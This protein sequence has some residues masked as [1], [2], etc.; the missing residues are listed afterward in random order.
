MKKQLPWKWLYVIG[1]CL[2]GLTFGAWQQN[3]FAGLWMSLL[4]AMIFRL[5][6]DCVYPD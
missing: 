1:T 3:F 2:L 5:V 6:E 4:F